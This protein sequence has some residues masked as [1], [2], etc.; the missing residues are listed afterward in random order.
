MST[1]DVNE[2]MQQMGERARAAA[3]AMARASAASKNAALRE[4]ARLLGESGAA[5]DAATAQQRL[6]FQF[7]GHRRRAWRGLRDCGCRRA[8]QQRGKQGKDAEF[9]VSPALQIATVSR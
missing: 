9:H 8:H 2:L 5:L 6:H 7:L 3:T 1:Q 4:L